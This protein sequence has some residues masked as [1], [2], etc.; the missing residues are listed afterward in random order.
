MRV[1]AGERRTRFQKKAGW[2]ALVLVF[3]TTAVPSCTKR[4]GEAHSSPASPGSGFATPRR[5]A[6]ASPANASPANASPANASPATQESLALYQA[7]SNALRAGDRASAQHAFDQAIAELERATG[8]HLELRVPN[9]YDISEGRGLDIVASSPD[10]ATLAICDRF[11]VVLLDA[12]SGRE[13]L[14]FSTGV[15]T[16]SLSFRRDGGLLAVA[17][18]DGA[19]RLYDPKKAQLVGTL[20]GSVDTAL[21]LFFAPDQDTLVVGAEDGTLRFWNL[22]ERTLAR[23]LTGSTTTSSGKHSVSADGEKTEW[24]ELRGNAQFAFSPD[25]T[26]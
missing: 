25:G 14:R 10:A 8:R 2:G 17:G 15:F 24:H 9:Q 7:G 21:S 22:S 19:V 16:E 20:P 5:A 26:V 18:R 13:R 4:P 11:D 1:V 23:T 12:R 3:L 6:N